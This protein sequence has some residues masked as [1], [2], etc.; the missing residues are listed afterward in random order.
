MDMAVPLVRSISHRC[1]EWWSIRREL[2]DPRVRAAVR[3]ASQALGLTVH[4]VQLLARGGSAFV[5]RAKTHGTDLVLKVPRYALW[6]ADQP[7]Q[8]D[9]QLKREARILGSA[10]VGCIPT[11]V[12]AH[13]EGRYLFRELVEGVSLERSVR[14]A[15]GRGNSRAALVR[16]LVA[17]ARVLFSA[18]HSS[19]HGSFV[20]RDFKPRNIVTEAATGRLAL[21]DVGSV[22]REGR[23]SATRDAVWRLGSGKWLFWAPEQ[24]LGRPDVDRRA[25]YFALGATAFFVLSGTAPYSNLETVPERAERDYGCRY[26]TV[27][28]RLDLLAGEAG[29]GP[30]VTEFL[31]NCLN[32]SPA[33]RPTRVPGRIELC[34]TS[35]A[36]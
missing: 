20:V 23:E 15:L 11:L 16:S 28:A 8:A 3:D 34:G 36:P 26:T 27:R 18:V 1:R 25:D 19:V 35:E 6:P 29:L 14:N 5:F 2:A 22:R 24:L 13:P 12:L 32:P 7:G 17:M 31:V 30:H 9:F 33:G 4:H 10:S 21:V